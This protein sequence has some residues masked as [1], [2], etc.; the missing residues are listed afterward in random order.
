MRLSPS[1]DRR[2]DPDPDRDRGVTPAVAV[3]LLVAIAVL[4]AAVT[5]GY[6][7]DLAREADD[8]A[9]RAA[10][11]YEWENASR[12]LTIT[13]QSGTAFTDANTGRLTVR[14]EDEDETGRNDFDVAERDWA[15]D[16]LSTYPIESGDR[17]VIT[18]EQGGGDLDVELAGTNSENFGGE[19][20]EPE[21]NDVVTVTWT[22]PDGEE[23]YVI[24]RMTVPR[25]EDP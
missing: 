24:Y 12:T 17:F 4:L 6:V 20:H 25:G 13:H 15:N 18:G 1:D 21:I 23:S 22:G 19:I 10:F 9:P 8:P 16:S 3:V 2:R 11:V 14:I 7:T 5:G